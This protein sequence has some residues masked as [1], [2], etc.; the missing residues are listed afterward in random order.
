MDPETRETP[1]VTTEQIDAHLRRMRVL[2]M[3][4]EILIL[5][6]AISCWFL[7]Q[8]APTILGRG[9][10]SLLMAF[11]AL[12]LGF[13]SSR[14]AKARMERIRRAFG[15]HGDVSRLLRDH[16]IAFGWILLRMLMI[17]VGGLLIAGWGSGPGFS[18][19]LSALAFL[20]ALMTFP[21]EYKTRLLLKRASME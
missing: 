15:V 20:L 19:L 3:L 13:S 1:S 21:T 2:W 17:A 16:V 7:Q 10:F 9:G 5:S 8:R 14:D 18:I 11:V 4:G 6:A 12:W